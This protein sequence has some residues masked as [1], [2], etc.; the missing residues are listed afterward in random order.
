MAKM[1]LGAGAEKRGNYWEIPIRNIEIRDE[2]NFSRAYPVGQSKDDRKGIETLAMSIMEQGQEQPCIGDLSG[3]DG[4]VRLKVGFRR[5]AAALWLD[6]K[7]LSENHKLLIEV[8]EKEITVAEA[9]ALNIGENAQRKDM[10]PMDI[11][12]ACGALKEKE[13]NG[14]DIARIV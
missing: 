5:G 12:A 6:E 3:T 7:G 8:R 10:T 9:M 4:K 13:F 1:N 11:A 2:D 14:K